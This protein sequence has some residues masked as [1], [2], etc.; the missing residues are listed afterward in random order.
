GKSQYDS[1]DKYTDQHHQK[2]VETRHVPACVQKH[3]GEEHGGNTRQA[4]EDEDT[5]LGHPGRARPEV[6]KII[7]LQGSLRKRQQQDIHYVIDICRIPY[8]EI[9]KQVV[10]QHDQDHAE[11]QSEDQVLLHQ[12]LIDILGLADIQRERDLLAA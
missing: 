12:C 9:D 3:L 10:K 6:F 7:S 5:V 4:G 11:K 8:G 1:D 2:T